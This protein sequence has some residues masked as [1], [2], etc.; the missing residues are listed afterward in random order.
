MKQVSSVPSPPWTCFFSVGMVEELDLEGDPIPGTEEVP[1]D[2]VTM[3][4]KTEASVH[5]KNFT[6]R[7][8]PSLNLNPWPFWNFLS[9]SSSIQLPFQTL[10]FSRLFLNY[11]F[12]GLGTFVC[13]ARARPMRFGW[14]GKKTCSETFIS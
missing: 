5:Q 14:M 1:A 8:G 10:P 2:V 12:F 11:R 9:S 4:Q 3:T 6:R 7:S 13:L